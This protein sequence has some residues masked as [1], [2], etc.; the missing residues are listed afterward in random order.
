MEDGDDFYMEAFWNLHTCRQLGMS[1]GWIP[2]I[3]ME[4]YATVW[5]L[6]ED[7][8]RAFIMVI[9]SMDGAYLEWEHEQS[10]ERRRANSPP[11]G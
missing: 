5:G 1:M 2:W 8:T 4:R 10:E 3:A 6:D 9:R 7:N 11:E